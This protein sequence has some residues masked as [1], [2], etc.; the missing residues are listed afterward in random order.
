DGFE[1]VLDLIERGAAGLLDEIRG[2]Q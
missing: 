1:Q 2:R